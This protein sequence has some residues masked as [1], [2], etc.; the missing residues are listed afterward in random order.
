MEGH[1][2]RVNSRDAGRRQHHELLFRRLA[3]VFQESGFACPRLSRQKYGLPRERNELERFLKFLVVCI[4]LEV[5]VNNQASLY[6][7]F[8]RSVF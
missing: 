3:N 2:A 5:H 4:Y 6:F 8:F 1:A 7:G